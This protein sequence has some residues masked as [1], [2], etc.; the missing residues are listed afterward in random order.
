[1]PNDSNLE[2]TIIVNQTWKMAESADI[3]VLKLILIG[4]GTRGIGVGKTCLLMEY[5]GY[6]YTEVAYV[7]HV[8]DETRV[9]VKIADVQHYLLLHD[10]GGGVRT[11]Y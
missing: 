3:P 6:H 4:N 5:L 1:M 2:F 7:P 8:F 10:T 11:G 9:S